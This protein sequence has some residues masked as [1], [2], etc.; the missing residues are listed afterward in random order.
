MLRGKLD[1]ALFVKPPFIIPKTLRMVEIR[2]EPLMLV[3]QA[4]V[5]ANHIRHVLKT[6]AFICYDPHSSGGRLVQRYL[7][8][9]KTSP[10]IVCNIDALETIVILAARG[11]GNALV[12]A[13]Q[14][15]ETDGIT[16]SPVP[17][18]VDLLVG[19]LLEG[20]GVIGG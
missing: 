18:A 11:L 8:A 10:D 5:S 2:A 1:A 7:D 3:S 19:I 4:P 6:H 14:G 13:W 12:P 15:A 17:N 9:E 16:L 20:W